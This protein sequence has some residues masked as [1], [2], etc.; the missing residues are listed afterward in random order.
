MIEVKS[1]IDLKMSSKEGQKLWVNFR[2]YAQYD[3]LKELYRK[4]MPAISG[5]EDKLKE[6]NDHNVKLDNMMLR[7]D[8][9]LCKK[10]DKTQVTEFRDH[11][12]RNFETKDEAGVI[13]EI[14]TSKVDSFAKR[15]DDVEEMVKF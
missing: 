11:A 8:T 9:V 1:E 3:E 4:C 13:Q 6:N 2:K 12:D 14:V 7:M 15:C 5:F 10:A